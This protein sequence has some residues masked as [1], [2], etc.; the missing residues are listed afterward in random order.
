MLFRI[1]AGNLEP[2]INVGGYYGKFT[3]GR[4]KIAFDEEISE[5]GFSY[6]ND[7][8]KEII[9]INEQ[10]MKSQWG[11]SAGAGL[12]YTI[13]YFRLG[14]ELSYKLSQFNI[15]N[16][17]ERYSD[18]HLISKYF[19]V[20]DDLNLNNLELTINMFM[21]VDNLIHLHSSQKSKGGRS[22]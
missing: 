10:L 9:A 5:G 17:K 1:K 20:P 19:D 21:P 11:I 15:T 14:L 4:K 2:Y 18:K 8:Q 22:K 16:V 12:S 6:K 3:G 13:Q 7:S